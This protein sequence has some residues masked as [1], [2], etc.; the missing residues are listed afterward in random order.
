MKTLCCESTWTRKSRGYFTCDKCKQDVTIEI[1]LR[2]KEE[3]KYKTKIAD[4]AKELK[5]TR[6]CVYSWCN[7][8]KIRYHKGISSEDVERLRRIKEMRSQGL[9]TVEGAIRLSANPQ[10]LNLAKIY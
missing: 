4:I 10:N 7:E 2:T 1:Y 6:E 8:A 3:M 5:L 9:Y